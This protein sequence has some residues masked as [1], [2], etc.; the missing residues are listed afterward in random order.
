MTETRQKEPYRKEELRGIFVLGLLAVL[1]SFRFAQTTDSLMFSL[2][3]ASFNLIPILDITIALW[4]LYAFFM[5]IGF[6]DYELGK[7]IAEAFQN[8]SKAFLII[9]FLI[10]GFF[11]LVIYNDAY[12][13]RWYWVGGIFLLLIFGRIIRRIRKTENINFRQVLRNLKE[14]TKSDF[15]DTFD[16]IIVIFIGASV[17]LTLVIIDSQVIYGFIASSALIIVYSITKAIKKE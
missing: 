11:G 5:V 16:Q 3:Q 13:N 9:N 4:S 17:I 10:L 1:G 14:Q 8:I 6:S 7:N 12:P 15:W 2:G